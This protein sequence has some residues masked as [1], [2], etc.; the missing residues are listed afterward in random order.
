MAIMP[1]LI[2]SRRLSF[3]MCLS[4][5][6][7]SIKFAD[8]WI[9]PTSTRTSVSNHGRTRS[10]MLMLPAVDNMMMLAASPSVSASSSSFLMLLSNNSVE[11]WREYVPL[12]VSAAVMVDI[13]MGRPVANAIMKPLSQQA[14]SP[15]ENTDAMTKTNPKER[16]DTERIAQEALNQAYASMELRRY[17]DE[18]KTEAQRLQEI[19]QRMDAELRQVDAKLGERRQQLLGGDSDDMGL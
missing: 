4:S 6:L 10:T 11:S 14:S 12:V 1:I 13:A 18:N 2:Q 17:L 8:A 19:R 5:L 16:V 7:A 3:W 9:P 15:S